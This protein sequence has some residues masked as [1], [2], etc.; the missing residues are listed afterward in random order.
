MVWRY[1]RR[2]RCG[3]R[4]DLLKGGDN[5]YLGE[6]SIIPGDLNKFSAMI[7]FNSTEFSRIRIQYNYSKAMVL[8]NELKGFSEIFINCNLAIGAH[9]AHK[10]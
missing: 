4:Y 6:N 8:D 7:E 1:S 3:L 9:G 5:L 2:W 10:F